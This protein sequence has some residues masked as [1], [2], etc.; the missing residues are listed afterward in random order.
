MRRQTASR[1]LSI[2][3][4]HKKSGRVIRDTYNAQWGKHWWQRFG[5]V[6]FY[7]HMGR[8]EDL[9]FVIGENRDSV[10]NVS[11]T[12]SFTYKE[13]W[14][15]ITAEGKAFLIQNSPH[16]EGHHHGSPSHLP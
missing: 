3:S 2:I 11:E 13:R 8:L 5:L 1:L 9:N 16:P 12:E 6:G 7:L 14:Y 15:T 4:D 10:A